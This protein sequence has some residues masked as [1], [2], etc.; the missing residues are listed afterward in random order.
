MFPGLRTG[1][2]RNPTARTRARPPDPATHDVV[3]VIINTFRDK[4]PGW[5]EGFGTVIL[6]EAHEYHSPQNGK[7]LWLAQTPAVLGLSATPLERPDGL[8]RYVTYHLGPPISAAAIPGFDVSA[9]NF[10]AA[11]REIVYGGHPDHCETVSTPQGVMSAVL[12][13]DS[14]LGDPYRLRLVAAE[15]A[16]LYHLHRTASP[17][18]LEAWGLGPRPE[19]AATPSLP[20]GGVRRHGVFVFAELRRYLPALREALLAHFAPEE[21][22]APELEEEAFGPALDCPQVST[23]M[24]GVAP[25]AVGDARRAGAHVVLT[26][27]GYS[28]RGISLTEM[29]SIILASPRRNGMRQILGR[30]FRRGSDE[31]IVRQVV[32]IVD[33]RTGLRGQATDRRKL[34][35]ER[36]YP[37]TRLAIDWRD[38]ASDDP[39]AD[40]GAVAAAPEAPEEQA[41]ADMPTQELLALCLGED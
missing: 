11:V 33:S 35:A 21:V 32:D 9:V 30:I 38:L 8:D 17:A 24:G 12:T 2:Y 20:A 36:G 28:R 37:S 26:T 25:S 23:L 40:L 13:V 18:E 15:A 31:S 3:V 4:D 19:S 14:I 16:R 29:T 39:T 27:Y 22:A 5:M 10:R 41:L 6:D 7:A 34:Y 1:F